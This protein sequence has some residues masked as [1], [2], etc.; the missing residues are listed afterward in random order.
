M[1][2]TSAA[3]ICGFVVV[4]AAKR[5]RPAA[6]PCGWAIRVPVVA[7]RLKYARKL[8][9][10]IAYMERASAVLPMVSHRENIELGMESMTAA[11]VPAT[12]ILPIM[13]AVAFLSAHAG[14]T[15]KTFS[16]IWAAVLLATPSTVSIITVIMNPLTASGPHQVSKTKTDVRSSVTNAEISF[17][18]EAD[19][20]R[21]AAD[22]TR[23]A[24]D[25]VRTATAA[26]YGRA[27][28]I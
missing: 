16:L 9:N 12:R 20:T 28:S 1:A 14:M 5:S 26:D 15:I 27:L 23:H 25:S 10:A 11:A 19:G 18:N 22:L 3:I 21:T 2:A 8:A 4:I 24:A 7:S 13:V 17:G 6:I